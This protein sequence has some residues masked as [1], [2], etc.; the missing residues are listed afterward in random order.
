MSRS[1]TGPDAGAVGL[2]PGEDFEESVEAFTG[3]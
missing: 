1:G 3:E 2:D